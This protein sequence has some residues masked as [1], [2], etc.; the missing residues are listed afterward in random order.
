MGAYLQYEVMPVAL[1]DKVWP[2]GL[3]PR[4]PNELDEG[5]VE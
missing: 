4:Y 2:S 3:V 5:S 1:E